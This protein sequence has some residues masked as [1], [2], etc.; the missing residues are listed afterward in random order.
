[1]TV[2]ELIKLLS[3]CDPERIV[4][5]AKDA[6]GRGNSYSPCRGAWRGKYLADTTY[7]G[8]VG[9]DGDKEGERAL[10]LTPVN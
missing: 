9:L 4:V 10:I 5:M 1:M 3:E 2:G 8:D 7:S 6:E